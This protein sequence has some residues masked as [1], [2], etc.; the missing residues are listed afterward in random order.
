MSLCGPANM[1]SSCVSGLMTRVSVRSFCSGGGAR[2]DGESLGR[3]KF[4]FPQ[5]QTEGRRRRTHKLCELVVADAAVGSLEALGVEDAALRVDVAEAD[6]GE[7]LHRR[8]LL[9]KPASRLTFV[10]RLGSL[11]IQCR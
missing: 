4:C 1:S 3:R 7:D 9:R 5:W 10:D 11:K 6:G 2:G 8:R